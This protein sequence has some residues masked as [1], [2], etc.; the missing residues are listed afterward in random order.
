MELCGHRVDI[1]PPRQRNLCKFYYP[2]FSSLLPITP[3]HA[4]NI[5][6]IEAPCVNSTFCTVPA[7]DT[8]VCHLDL[9]MPSILGVVGALTG[10]VHVTA[11]LHHERNVVSFHHIHRSRRLQHL[12]ARGS[13]M[14][15]SA[16]KLALLVSGFCGV[17]IFATDG[18]SNTLH[19]IATGDSTS[20][21]RDDVGVAKLL[22]HVY[23]LYADM[24]A[25]SNEVT[26]SG[27]MGLGRLSSL[28]FYFFH[29]ENKG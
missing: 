3:E 6:S 14:C 21:P 15:V 24:R 29:V 5:N 12:R 7:D 28:V 19:F 16:F 22:H 2:A 20:Q 17:A 13:D 1:S 23:H 27:W 26:V 4:Q 25:G 11:Y 9:Y 18:L 8:T 10:L